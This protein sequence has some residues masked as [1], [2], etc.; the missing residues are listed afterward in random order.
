MNGRI[1]NKILSSEKRAKFSSEQGKILYC[2]W[3][4]TPLTATD[5]SI[6]TGLAKNT[7]TSMLK[8]LEKSGLV[9][10]YPHPSDKRMR[11]FDLTE[12]GKKQKFVGEA[13]SKK[14][15]EIFYKNF[16]KED[17]QIFEELLDRIIKNL[18]TGDQNF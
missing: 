15:S 2:L 16:T 9:C 18:E 5:L 4:K 7:L 13:A 1:F 11:Y 10:S 17:S 8:R 12:E 3:R 14:L 6:E